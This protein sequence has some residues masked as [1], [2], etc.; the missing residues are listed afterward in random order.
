VLFTELQGRLPADW[1]TPM[2]REGKVTLSAV[3]GGSAV[4]VRRPTLGIKHVAEGMEVYRYGSRTFRVGAGQFLIVPEQLE[5]EFTV[6]SS[7]VAA[8][9][10]L[11]LAISSLNGEECPI[12]QPMVFSDRCSGLGVL[13]ASAHRRLRLR[14]PDRAAIASALVKHV[15][16]QA[17][18]LLEATS[19]QLAAI[20]AAKRS[21]R[22]DRLRRLNVARSYLHE[23]IDRPISLSEL[24]RIS[25]MS[26]FHLLRNFRDCF[27]APPS[28]YHMHLRLEAARRALAGNRLTCSETALRFGFSDASSFSHAFKR[29][30]GLSPVSCSRSASESD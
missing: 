16:E 7:E 1:A 28:T 2:P 5:G 25:G 27:G 13:L 12:E 4:A 22:E 9:L 24:A 20:N 6:A 17:E 21:T 29:E 23:V 10:C 14:R 30:F 15:T 18:P 3:A 26:R 11:N 8:G 19:R